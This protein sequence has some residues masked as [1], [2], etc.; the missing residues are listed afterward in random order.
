VSALAP[1]TLVVG[2]AEAVGGDT[3]L[4]RPFGPSPLIS[5]YANVCSIFISILETLFSVVKS[6]LALT[7]PQLRQPTV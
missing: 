3:I 5:S 6:L 7:Q 2:L 4:F 1:S